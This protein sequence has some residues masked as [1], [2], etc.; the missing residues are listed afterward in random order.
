M[1]QIFLLA[2]VAAL[3]ASGAADDAPK[4][5]APLSEHGEKAQEC[6]AINPDRPLSCCEGYVC[7]NTGFK[8]VG[9]SSTPAVEDESGGVTSVS[10][11]HLTLPTKA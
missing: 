4:C 1:K 3:A 11:T 5:A 7:A 6:G 10:Y 8:C 2:V 9:E